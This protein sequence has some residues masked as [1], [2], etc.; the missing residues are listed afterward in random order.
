MTQQHTQTSSR[1]PEQTREDSQMSIDSSLASFTKVE[2][3]VEL[4]QVSLYLNSFSLEEP[5]MF[6]NLSLE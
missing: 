2:T 5:S 1:K 4:K 6:I 3:K